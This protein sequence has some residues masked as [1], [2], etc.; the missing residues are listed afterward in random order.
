MNPQLPEGKAFNSFGG[1][2][3]AVQIYQNQLEVEETLKTNVI[4]NRAVLQ[5]RDPYW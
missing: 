2:L 3:V 1:V 5:S 4:N